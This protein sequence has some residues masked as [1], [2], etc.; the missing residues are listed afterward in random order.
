METAWTSKG[1]RLNAYHACIPGD[2]Y[3]DN[4]PGLTSFEDYAIT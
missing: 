3:P 1:A 4:S 2:T